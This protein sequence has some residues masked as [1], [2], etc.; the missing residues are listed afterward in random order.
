MDGHLFFVQ[1]GY[2]IFSGRRN[3]EKKTA[4]Q[5]NR[6]HEDCRILG[7]NDMRMEEKTDEDRVMK[8]K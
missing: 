6:G 3:I 4:E 1:N 5:W 2:R 7:Q 8:K